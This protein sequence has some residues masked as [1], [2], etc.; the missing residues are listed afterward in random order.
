MSKKIFLVTL[1]IFILTGSCLS[2][3]AN[4]DNEWVLDEP[5]VLTNETENRIKT[6]NKEVFP[7]YKEKPQLGI[8]IINN[9]PSGI[10]MDEYKLDMFNE[11]GVGTKEEN[12]GMLFVFAINDKKY[13]FEIGDGFEKGSLLRKDLETDFINEDMK[14]LLKE[15]NYDTVINQ[16]V[17]YLETLMK[18]EENGVYFIKEQE[19]AKQKEIEKEKVKQG[20]KTLGLISVIAISISFIVKVTLLYLRKRKISKILNNYNKYLSLIKMDKQ[21]IIQKIYEDSEDFKNIEN[22]VTNSLYN[23]YMSEQKE[24]INTQKLSTSSSRYINYMESQNTLQNFISF[25]LKNIETICYEV[26]KQ[27]E[28]ECKIKN[29][30]IEKVK[31]FLELNKDRIENK[32][33]NIQVLKENILSCC[34]IKNVISDNELED[35][36]NKELKALNFKYEYDEFVKEY[37][38]S[39]NSSYFDSSSF[40]NELQ[41]SK[42]YSDFCY[43]RNYDRTWM[44]IMLFSHMQKNEKKAKER[45][46]REER[47]RKERARREAEERAS[48]SSFGSSFGGGSS[49]GGGFSGGW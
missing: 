32:N 16:V 25:Q 30:N 39:I 49:S 34:P 8:M 17:T 13:G 47:K 1:L 38:D 28:T 18:D 6:L 36:F 33:I 45:A 44:K 3:Y 41:H 35:T 20:L 4:T 11:Y 15:E 48:S 46:E 40:Y 23:I 43:R 2:V 22:I 19:L 27:I 26:D 10:S 5:N 7:A 42:E 37:K 31:D 24:L 14:S 21:D 9:L 29:E 12:R